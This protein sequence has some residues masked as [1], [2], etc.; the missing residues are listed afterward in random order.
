MLQEIADWGE[1]LPEQCET[2]FSTVIVSLQECL[3]YLVFVGLHDMADFQES[4]P[5]SI[6]L[7]LQTK[8]RGQQAE[9]KTIFKSSGII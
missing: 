8:E 4:L 7:E 5:S 1:W 2:A 9:K 3:V 6:V